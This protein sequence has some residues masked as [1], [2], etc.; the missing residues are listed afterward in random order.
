MSE[1]IGMY[2]NGSQQVKNISK[3]SER[4]ENLTKPFANY[5]NFEGS[6]QLRRPKPKLSPAGRPAVLHLP[7]RQKNFRGGPSPGLSKMSPGYRFWADLANL[8]RRMDPWDPPQT[9]SRYG[10]GG[11]TKRRYENL[12]T[13]P[14]SCWDFFFRFCR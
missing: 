14:Q 7:K 5:Q 2:P 13:Q 12:I 3:S 10:G 8:P 4:R 6:Q 11:G 9:P 1:H